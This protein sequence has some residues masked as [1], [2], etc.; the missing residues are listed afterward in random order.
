MMKTTQR[1]QKIYA[2]QRRKPLEFQEGEHVFFRVTSTIGVVRA[3]K[4]KKLTPKFIGPYHI[5]RR[6]SLVAYQIAL[7][8]SLA[9]LHDVFHV[10]QLRK[11]M[12]DPSHIIMLDDIQLK[13]NIYFVI[14]PLSIGDRTTNHIQGKEIT[15]V[16]VI[17]DQTTGDATW[18]LEEKMREL[19]PNLFMSD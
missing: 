3:L 17:W 15:L 12:V 8:P 4:S 6:V 18:E 5:L 13:K 11:Y 14:P 1:R 10:S 16:N 7:P 19:Y 2:N 9:K